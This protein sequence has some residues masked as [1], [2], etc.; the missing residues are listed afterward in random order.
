MKITTELKV[1]TYECDSYGH[2]NNANYLHYLEYAR[3]DFL[4]QIGFDYNK[5]VEEGY[6][7]YITH[8]DIYYK[9]SARYGDTLHIETMPLK[10][11]AVSGTMSQ[12]VLNQDGKIVAEAEVSWACVNRESRPSKIPDAYKNTGLS[13]ETN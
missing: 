8:I 13:P 3:A 10:T 4:D 5:F 12:K 6:F 9:W 11:G 2:V 1:R 7:I